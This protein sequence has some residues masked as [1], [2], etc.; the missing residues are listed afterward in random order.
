M[1]PEESVHYQL[2]T[3]VGSEEWKTILPQGKGV[4]YPFNDSTPFRVAMFHQ[5]ECLDVIRTEMIH[6]RDNTSIAPSEKAHFCLNYLR[7]TVLCH[8]DRHLEMIVWIGNL[9]GGEWS[10]RKTLPRK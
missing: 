8:G 2:D 1:T 7:Q 6:R 9:F 3:L 5:L 4:I 10:I